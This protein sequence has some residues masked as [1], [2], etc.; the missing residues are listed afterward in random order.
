[1]VY[2]YLVVEVDGLT[3]RQ[4]ILRPEET[5]TPAVPPPPPPPATLAPYDEQ[6]EK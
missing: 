3:R 5:T 6:V 4:V 1:M 2:R